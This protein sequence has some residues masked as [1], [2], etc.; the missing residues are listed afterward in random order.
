MVAAVLGVIWKPALPNNNNIQDQPER[1]RGREFVEAASSCCPQVRMAVFTAYRM[2]TTMWK[3]SGS[4]IKRGRRHQYA[5]G[6]HVGSQVGFSSQMANKF[7]ELALGS[8][9]IRSPR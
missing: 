1:T 7:I 4:V 9:C 2:A 3:N 6:Q 8:V 5:T